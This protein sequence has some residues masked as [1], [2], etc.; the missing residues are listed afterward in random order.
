VL[1]QHA[2][3]L[4]VNF[5]TRVAGTKPASVVDMTAR[6]ALH[7]MTIALLA[8]V[9]LILTAHAQP[10]TAPPSSLPTMP[11]TP[12]MNDPARPATCDLCRPLEGRP[13]SDLQRHRRLRQK[14]LRPHK[15]APGVT[16]SPKRSLTSQLPRRKLEEEHED[17]AR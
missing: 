16:K 4:N 9:G 10:S 13:G 12:N 14:D 11:L 1:L 2:V 5:A 6:R 15:K 7:V 3:F 17:E 8:A